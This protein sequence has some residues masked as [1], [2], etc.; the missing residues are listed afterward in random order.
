MQAAT[1]ALRTLA[2]ASL[3]WPAAFLGRWRLADL[4]HA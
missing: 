1:P 2:R 4:R 3:A